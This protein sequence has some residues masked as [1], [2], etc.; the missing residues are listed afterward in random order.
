MWKLLCTDRKFL[1]P[2][3]S[4]TLIQK[5]MFAHGNIYWGNYSNWDPNMP[6]KIF[7][8]NKT[9]CRKSKLCNKMV[10]CISTK[11]DINYADTDRV[12][13][14]LL[15]KGYCNGKRKSF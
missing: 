11:V 9:C 8:L 1:I 4:I 3:K 7:N 14:L 2:V 10:D 15:S 12:R 5:G 13:H 6:G